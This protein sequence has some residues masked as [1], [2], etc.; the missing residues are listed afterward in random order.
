MTNKAVIIGISIVIIILLVIIVFIASAFSG[1]VFQ[2]FLETAVT[3]YFIL[4]YQ[5]ISVSYPVLWPDL[6]HGTACRQQ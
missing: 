4:I 1:G 2:L 3:V 6:H 5:Q